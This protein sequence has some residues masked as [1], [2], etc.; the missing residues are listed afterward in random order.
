MARFGN[1][2]AGG[3]GGFATTPLGKATV[4]AFLTPYNRMVRSQK[5]IKLKT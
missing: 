5:N 4:A 3:L 2:V 1:G